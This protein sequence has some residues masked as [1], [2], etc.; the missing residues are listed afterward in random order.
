MAAVTQARSVAVLLTR[1]GARHGAALGAACVV[2]RR[3]ARTA[4]RTASGSRYRRHEAGVGGRGASRSRVHLRRPVRGPAAGHE[5]TQPPSYPV[6]H[7]DDPAIDFVPRFAHPRRLM[8]FGTS[9]LDLARLDE[10]GLARWSP[11]GAVQAIRPMDLSIDGRDLFVLCAN[12]ELVGLDIETG[13]EI[14]RVAWVRP[15]HLVVRARAHRHGDRRR[16]RCRTRAHRRD[17]RADARRASGSMARLPPSM[18]ESRAP[19]RATRSSSSNAASVHPGSDARARSSTS[20]HWPSCESWETVRRHPVPSSHRTGAR[21]SSPTRCRSFPTAHRS[22]DRS[23][24][25]GDA[26]ACQCSRRL[27]DQ[28]RLRGT[29]P[30]TVLTVV[31]VSGGNVSMTWA[32]PAHSPAATGYRLAIGSAPNATNLGSLALGP[33]ARSPRPRAVR[34]L[35]RA[36]ARDEL[37]RRGLSLP[38]ARG[39]R[40]LTR[41]GVVR[42][43]G[44]TGQASACHRLGSAPADEY[45][46]SLAV[47][48]P[49]RCKI[50]R[51]RST[52]MASADPLRLVTVV[53]LSSE[54]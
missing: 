38:G 1:R 7:T 9:G 15:A 47:L 20:L 41:S 28:H 12:G 40:S 42:P 6:W 23:A 22:L 48:M 3:P 11:C 50:S 33:A 31:S 36:A 16:S 24:Y 8:L 4:R 18:P 51:T 13:A 25:R 30:P 2:P 27:V 21:S 54:L 10:R 46:R 34:P 14:R 35:L 39:R 52:G 49:C 26:D 45:G 19:R 5:L 37:H 43:S 29:A 44:R 17:H 32:L 53:A